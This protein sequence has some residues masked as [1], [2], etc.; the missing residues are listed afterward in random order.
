MELKGHYY[1]L[2]IK[3]TTAAVA[4]EDEETQL[5][6]NKETAIKSVSKNEK[7]I[8]LNKVCKEVALQNNKYNFKF[9]ENRRSRYGK[10]KIDKCALEYN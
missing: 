5:V 2:V 6:E 8:A 10:R 1:N 9:A 4:L 3:Q 7:E